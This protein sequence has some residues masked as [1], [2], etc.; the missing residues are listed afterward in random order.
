MISETENKLQGTK[1][2]SEWNLKEDVIRSN[3]AM[4]RSSAMAWVGLGLGLG[5]GLVLG[6]GLG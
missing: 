2:I 4:A 5:F 3:I 6:L 1:G